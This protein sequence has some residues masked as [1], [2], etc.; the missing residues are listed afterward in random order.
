MWVA[1]GSLGALS[2]AATLGTRGPGSLYSETLARKRPSGGCLMGPGPE[3]PVPGTRD[4]WHEPHND[5]AKLRDA[6]EAS[7]T[8]A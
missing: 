7:G 1:T 2:R 3:T 8:S 6:S 4:G 5:S